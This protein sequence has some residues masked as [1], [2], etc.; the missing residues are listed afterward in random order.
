MRKG[1]R[2]ETFFLLVM[3][4]KCLRSKKIKYSLKISDTPKGV[5]GLLEFDQHL[6][7]TTWLEGKLR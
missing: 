4:M 7:R 5:G 3:F 1:K 6:T 2:S